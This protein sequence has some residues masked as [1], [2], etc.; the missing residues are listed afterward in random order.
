[1]APYTS[2]GVISQIELNWVINSIDGHVHLLQ[3][4]AC[5][6]SVATMKTFFLKMQY[7][8]IL[9]ENINKRIAFVNIMWRNNSFVSGAITNTPL[10]TSCMAN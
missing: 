5:L 7:V 6:R 8:R 10:A 9:F 4:S 2:S 1:M 3:K